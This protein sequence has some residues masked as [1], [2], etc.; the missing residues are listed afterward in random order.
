MSVMMA[1]YYYHYHEEFCFTFFCSKQ[2]GS[3]VSTFPWD[4]DYAGIRACSNDRQHFKERTC[5]ETKFMPKLTAPGDIE[6]C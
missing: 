3:N 1:K 2:V 5:C 6:L 4:D